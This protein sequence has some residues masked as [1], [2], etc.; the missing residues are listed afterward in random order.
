MHDDTYIFIQARSG[1]SRL[2][3]KYSLPLPENGK[4]VSIVEHC[5][6]RLAATGIP[7][8]FLIPHDDK[9]IAGYLC[10]KNLPYFT[11]S[12]ENVRE[13]FLT[14][15]EKTG[16]EMILRATADNPCVDTEAALKTAHKLKEGYD[17]FSF[18]GLPLGCAVEAFRTDALAAFTDSNKDYEEHVS[19]HIKHN[20]DRFRVGHLPYFDDLCRSNRMPLRLT[21]D[22]QADYET[23]S[24]LFDRL[25]FDF[26][27]HE[28]CE[29][30]EKEPG[31]FGRNLH[32]I[33]K[34]F[35]AAH[36]RRS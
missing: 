15:A 34:T 5:Y 2:K 12:H 4:S 8:Y 20:T 31:F 36:Y 33:Q 30:A 1:S 29:L 9:T 3:D 22:E 10:E 28:V 26:N 35:P 25:G 14:A 6:R 16:A 18:T 19:L 27:V 7:V 23:V 13:R 17:L 11:G 24:A 21:I 32:V